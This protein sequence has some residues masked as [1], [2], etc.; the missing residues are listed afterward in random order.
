MV[1]SSVTLNFKARHYLTLNIAE[2]IRD[3]S[4]VTCS[5]RL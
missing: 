5:A 2:M 3:R 4:T 1:P